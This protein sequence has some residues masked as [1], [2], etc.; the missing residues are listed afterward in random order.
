MEKERER[1]RKNVCARVFVCFCG[2][3][4]EREIGRGKRKNWY[5]YGGFKP[6]CTGDANEGNR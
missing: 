3:E 4:K 2:R 1:V 5:I 6:V